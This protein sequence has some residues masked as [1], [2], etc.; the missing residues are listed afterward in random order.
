MAPQPLQIAD[1][2]GREPYLVR[3]LWWKVVGVYRFWLCER[4][5]ETKRFA[6]TKTPSSSDEA[7]GVVIEHTPI[8]THSI[9][10]SR[11]RT[12]KL[13]FN[14]FFL[15][16]LCRTAPNRRKKFRLPHLRI[17]ADRYLNIQNLHKLL[18]CNCLE[19][20]CK[21]PIDLKSCRKRQFSG[22]RSLRGQFFRLQWYVVAQFSKDHVLTEFVGG[23]E[24]G[25]FD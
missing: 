22:R 7:R 11:V 24:I 17:A 6:T 1:V 3:Y 8:L 18:L 16:F 19:M 14:R 25:F 23:I 2:V 15:V 21:N 5:S 9:N 12:Y 4:L 13:N 20:F 10:N